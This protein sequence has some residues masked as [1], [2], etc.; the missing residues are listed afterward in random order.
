[1]YENEIDINLVAPL[2]YVSDRMAMI[3]YYENLG[4]YYENNSGV[5]MYDGFNLCFKQAEAEQESLPNERLYGAMSVDVIAYMRGIELF[6]E[7]YKRAGV[8][9]YQPLIFNKANRKEFLIKDPGGYTTK[10]IQP[11]NDSNKRK[12]F[13]SGKVFYV[14]NVK[15][16]LKYYESIGF[17]CEYDSGLAYRDKIIIFFYE[18]PKL[19]SSVIETPDLINIYVGVE[20]GLETLYNELKNNN[21]LFVFHLRKNNE[22]KNEFCIKDPDDH[23]ILFIDF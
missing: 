18:V 19:G 23:K 4:L 20:F 6:Y 2:F 9:I 5:S 8:I 17:S 12:I 15:Q 11:V 3:E 10:F 7:E 13:Y 16:T 21:A 1:M 14:T 22:G